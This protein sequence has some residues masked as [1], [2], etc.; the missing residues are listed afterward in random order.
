M[1]LLT[2]EIDEWF[3]HHLNDFED[4]AL[5]AVSKGELDLGD[6][7]G[8]EAESKAEDSDD[9]HAALLSAF[10]DGLGERIKDVRI[11]HR[12]TSS[13]ACLVADEHEMGAH[14]ERILKSAGQQVTTAKPILE[15]NPDHP[16]IQRLSKEAD[17]ARQKD[18]AAILLEQAMLS[19]GGKLD[20]PAGFV[21][22][23]NEMFLAMISDGPAAAPAKPKAKKATK[24]KRVTKK[25]T[26]KAK[27]S[28]AG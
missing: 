8:E 15:I 24:K 19:E 27:K 2:E 17:S 25:T 6:I 9:T 18:W 14:L 20:D 26:A 16:M 11:T 21:R 10:R 12:L 5:H 23:L 1:L 13:P 4:H 3:V 28:E 22:K 7:D